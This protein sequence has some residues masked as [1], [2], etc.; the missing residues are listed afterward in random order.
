VLVPPDD[1]AA[2][3]AAL[4]ELADDGSLRLRFGERS[5]DIVSDWGYSGSVRG[6]ETLLRAVAGPVE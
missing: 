4:R 2:T 3:T 6:F 1:L 5:R